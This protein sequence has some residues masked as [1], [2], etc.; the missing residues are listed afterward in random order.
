AVQGKIVPISVSVTRT[1]I[2]DIGKDSGGDDKAAVYDESL[3]LTRDDGSH[4]G[5][6]S[7]VDPRLITNTT[8]RVAFDRKTAMAVNDPKY[9]ENVN[10]DPTIKH[11]GLS[12]EFPIDTE[13]K[14]YPFFDTVV[15]DAFPMNYAD[16]EKLQ[17]FTVYKF[18]QKI[19]NQPVLTNGVLPS[20]YTNTR[21][22]WVQ[23]TTGV[24]IKGQEE[25]TQTLTGRESL[26]P[27]SALRDPALQ[28]V[29]A[30]QGTLTFT[31]ATVH[32][33]ADL[34]NVYLPKIHLV[35]TWLPLIALVVGVLAPAG[36]ILLF[37]PRRRQSPP[38]EAPPPA[39]YPGE[40][41][42]PGYAAPSSDLAP[43]LPPDTE[44]TQPLP[45]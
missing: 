29:L 34:A 35:R 43:Q 4:P 8:D 25:L 19:V 30:L 18:V 9:R 20:L 41:A 12:Y 33:Q 40:P 27:N 2:G 5:C 10:G 15:G 31:P 13:K 16:S 36:V 28:N 24:I 11:K 44:V 1:I 21:T 3:C 17:G 23:P 6:V 14:T 32:N 37:V 22:V 38:S 26:D 7:K 45:R 42:P 39:P